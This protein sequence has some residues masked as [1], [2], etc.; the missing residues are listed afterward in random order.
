MSGR[1]LAG[2]GEEWALI[3]VR[4]F[5]HRFRRMGNTLTARRLTLLQGPLRLCG[6]RANRI[7]TSFGDLS[8]TLTFRLSNGALRRE[9]TS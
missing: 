5:G 7:V 4:E 3:R 8:R 9:I 1:V 6:L 2:G